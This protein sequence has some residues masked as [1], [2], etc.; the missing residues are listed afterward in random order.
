MPILCRIFDFILKNEP[1]QSVV[2]MSDLFNDTKNT[3]NYLEKSLLVIVIT[4]SK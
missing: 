1:V 3:P 2:A 4:F